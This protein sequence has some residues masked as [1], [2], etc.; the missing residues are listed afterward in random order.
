VTGLIATAVIILATGLLSAAGGAFVLYGL[1][2]LV[3]ATVLS[4][5]GE[6]GTRLL[7]ARV[8]KAGPIEFLVAAERIQ[9]YEVVQAKERDF[10]RPSF[11]IVIVFGN[12]LDLNIKLHR[13]R[14]YALES[15][16]IGENPTAPAANISRLQ[17]I[18]SLPSGKTAVLGDELKEL[19]ELYCIIEGYEKL[20]TLFDSQ[21]RGLLEEARSDKGKRNINLKEAVRI[22]SEFRQQA[23]DLKFVPPHSLTIKAYLH[24][25]LRKR[26]RL[27]DRISS[28]K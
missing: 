6:K 2:L 14:T 16:L 7:L 4:I 10:I 23:T 28:S 9:Y 26:D 18:E 8:Q 20:K 25:L 15:K 12:A 13:L 27:R 21:I 19:K 3:I 5:L 22:I 24:L 1:I 11:P 17:W